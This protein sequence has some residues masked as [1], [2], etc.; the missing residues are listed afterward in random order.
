MPPDDCWDPWLYPF[1][2]LLHFFKS[3]TDS[4]LS[5]P[6]SYPPSCPPPWTSIHSP[7]PKQTLTPISFASPGSFPWRTGTSGAAH[8]G[9]FFTSTTMV[10]VYCGFGGFLI[11]TMILCA[12]LRRS[13]AGSAA[14]LECSD[15]MTGPLVE[16]PGLPS[17]CMIQI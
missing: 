13:G 9:D 3:L 7:T 8:E 1:L 17:E 11:V 14:R 6:A 16:D 15:Q 4:D 5:G 2:W 10:L 12:V